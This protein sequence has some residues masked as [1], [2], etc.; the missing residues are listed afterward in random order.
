MIILPEMI[1]GMKRKLCDNKILMIDCQRENENLPK[2]DVGFNQQ[3]MYTLSH[4]FHCIFRRD[5]DQT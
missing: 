5:L 4:S 2:E 1:V 3:S